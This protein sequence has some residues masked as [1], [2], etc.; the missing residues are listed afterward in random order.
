MTYKPHTDQPL[1]VGCYLDN[2]RGHYI[3]RDVVD[4]AESFGYIV[5]PITRWF[6]DCYEDQSHED[7]YPAELVHE[8][9]DE[10][11]AWLNNGQEAR[12]SGQ[13]FPPV[14]PEDTAWSFNDGDF[15]LYPIDGLCD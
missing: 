13:N 10:A 12:I 15:G 1:E 4:L 3:A 5:D 14:I 9:A 8:L 2:H 11:E 6:L 7:N